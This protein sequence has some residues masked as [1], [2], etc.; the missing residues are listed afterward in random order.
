MGSVL[1]RGY[2]NTWTG[3]YEA[4]EDYDFDTLST[5]IDVEAIT[6]RYCVESTAGGCMDW[7]SFETYEVDQNEIYPASSF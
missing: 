2:F 7:E 4:M 3:K 1:I 5:G 6:G